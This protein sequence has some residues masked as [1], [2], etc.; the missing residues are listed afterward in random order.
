MKIFHRKA[1]KEDELAALADGS[2]P[3]ERRAEAEARVAASPELAA[4]LDE[5]RTAVT[6]IRGVE[7]DAPPRLRARVDAERARRTRAERARRTRRRP[8]PLAVAGGFAVAAAAALALVV[9]LPEGAGSPSVAQ[10]AGFATRGADDPAP[11]P[12]AGRPQL[13]AAGV[14][15]VAFPAWADEFGWR[16]SG[17]RDDPLEERDT[18]TVFYA[19]EGKEIGYTIVAGDALRVPEDARATRRRGVELH[20][21][22]ADGRTVVTWLR[23]GRSCVL[24]GA[25]VPEA[26]L[27]KLAAWNGGG[28]VR[29]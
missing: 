9:A 10:A 13:L 16:A 12:L 26:T 8:R 24:S 23:R 2:L 29:F 27:V 28:A 15:G 5:Q 4:R 21:F 22:E 6:A 18:T 19:K 1:F 14:D 25:G 7:A 3:P 11:A 17:R 20:V